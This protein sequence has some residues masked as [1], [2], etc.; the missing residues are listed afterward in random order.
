M[1]A[2]RTGLL[3]ATEQEQAQFFARLQEGFL[4]ASARTGEIIRD[5]RLAGTLVRLRFAGE[6]LIPLIVPGL[7]KG[8]AGGVSEPACEIRLWDSESTGLPP[9]PRP[10]PV[11]DFTLRGNIWGFDSSRYRSAYQWGEGSVTAMDCETRQAVFWVPTHRHFPV[12]AQAAPLRSILH[13]CMEI[14][15]R[16]LVHAAA[17]GCG[18]RGVLIPGRGGS[19][20][21]STSL[22][23]L[24]AGMDFVADD[25]LVLA[26]D[27]EPL[28]Y[29]LYSTAKLD[30]ASLI[31]YPDLAARCRT[32]HQPGFDKVVL[33]LEDGYAEQLK[34]SLP[35]K[36]AL[37]PSI[38]GLPETALGEAEPLEI[39]RA[40]AYD[41]LAQLPHAGAG[42]VEF[43]NRISREVPRSAIYLGTDRARI[44]TASFGD[45]ARWPHQRSLS[46][47]TPT[48]CFPPIPRRARSPA[49]FMRRSPDCRS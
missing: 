29:R 27:P 9:A 41:T 45:C 43:L 38:S 13:W 24:L 36:L 17:V 33:F 10:R 4:S 22:A 26:L 34:E 49:S 42:T 11:R 19:G 21:S 40:L 47:C 7:A 2:A 46:A 25:Y 8:V 31:L 44:A 35:L 12:W 5:F 18:G 3:P 14:N 37:K 39:E 16:Q 1:N 20:K 15:G 28:A 48:G 32:V 6:A 23:C 30:P